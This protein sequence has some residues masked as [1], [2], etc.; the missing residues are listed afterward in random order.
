MNKFI[1]INAKLKILK[2]TILNNK[3]FILNFKIV[4]INGNYSNI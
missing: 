2:I 3:S 1:N 4:N